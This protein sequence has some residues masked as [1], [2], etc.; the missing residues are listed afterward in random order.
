MNLPNRTESLRQRKRRETRQRIFDTAS[1][2][3]AR[4][5]Y[6]NVTVEDICQGADISRRTFFNYMDSKDEAVLGPSP[7]KFTSESFARIANEQSTNMLALIIDAMEESGAVT[8]VE[9]VCRLQRLVQDNPSL[10]NAMLVRKRDALHQ[11][12]QAVRDH[13]KRHPEDRRLDAA[14]DAEARIIVELVRT[15]LVLFAR[16]PH[17]QEE[18]PP[19]V[20]ARRIAA[21]ITKYVEELQW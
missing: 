7:L 15:T 18:E 10:A 14:V 9:D 12:E 4:D 6:D 5:G 3:V 13:L 8:G 19:K 17:F 11:L 16:S 21:I 1:S 20:Q 2:L